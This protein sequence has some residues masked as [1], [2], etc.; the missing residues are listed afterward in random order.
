[1]RYI[2]FDLDGTLTEPKEGIAN[3]IMYA[4]ERIGV[5]HSKNIDDY[6]KY[7]GPPLRESFVKYGNVD[8]DRVEEALSLYR[9]YYSVKGILE[10]ELYP[11]IDEL[12]SRLK[13]DGYKLALATSKPHVYA[14]RVL[15]C[16]DLNKYFDFISGSE[17]DGTR[18]SK[19]D[20]VKYALDELMISANDAI[21]VGDRSFDALG[22]GEHGVRCIGVTYGHGTK[23]ELINAGAVDMADDTNELYEKIIQLDKNM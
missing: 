16:F 13:A 23:E 20:V 2:F 4:F 3:S 7:I 22:A 8:A 10:N 6:G 18:D 19:S 12:L 5:P 9:E 11:G 1:M 14:V 21:M 17:L 15:E